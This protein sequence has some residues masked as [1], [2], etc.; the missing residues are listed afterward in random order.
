MTTV[1]IEEVSAEIA[2]D[3]EASTFSAGRA[4]LTAFLGIFAALGWVAGRT[5]YLTR[6]ARAAVKLGYY[7]GAHITPEMR[8]KKLADR[9]ARVAAQKPQSRQ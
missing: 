4:L 7:K 8:A 6:T 9:R 2:A 5:L 1:S 3:R